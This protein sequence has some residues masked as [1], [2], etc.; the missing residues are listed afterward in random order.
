[1]NRPWVIWTVLGLCALLIVGAMAWST[2]KVLVLE[3]RQTLAESSA[4]LEERIRLSLSRMDIAASGLL[5]LENQRPPHHFKAYFEPEDVFTNKFQVVGKGIVVQPSPLLPELPEFVRL[6]FEVDAATR[7]VNSPQVPTGN[8]R[9]SAEGNGIKT[10]YLDAAFDDLNAL[11]TLLDQPSLSET[12]SQTML[13]EICTAFVSVNDAWGGK[14]TSWNILKSSVVQQKEAWVKEARGDNRA[15]IT[16]GKQYQQEVAIIEKSKRAEVLNDNYERAIPK[17]SQTLR[18]GSPVQI[19]QIAEEVQRQQSSA[20]GPVAQSR[21]VQENAGSSGGYLDNNIVELPMKV[22][23]FQ[24]VWLAKELLIVRQVAIAGKLRYQG[25]WLRAN[26]LSEYLLSAASDLL[27]EAGLE[28]I[29]EISGR[30]LPGTIKVKLDE[31]SNDPLSLVTLPW[32]LRAGEFPVAANVGW[33]ALRISLVVGWVALV[34]ALL[35][36]AVLV[37]GV[38]KLSDR[39]ATFVS[40]VTHELRTPLTT[41][42]LYSDMLVEGMVKDEKKKKEYLTTMRQEAERLNHL[43]ENVLAYSRVERGSARTEHQNV[44]LASL[45]ERM[46]PRL[47]ERVCKD[48]AKLAVESMSDAAQVRVETDLTAVEQIVFNLVDNACKYGLPDEGER[49]IHLR[50]ANGGR[51]ARIEVSDEGGGIAQADEKKLFRPFH[52]SARDAA[53]S[54]PGVGLGLALSRRL[55]RELGGE[56]RID[57]ER[58]RGACFVLELPIAKK[59]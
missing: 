53:H 26:K 37:R 30:L 40:S 54:K 43:V 32:R 18:N 17:Q 4:E 20:Q 19:Q 25:A 27:P 59:R 48:E 12:G 36:S 5:L 3:G 41:F 6:H 23:P 16:R 52:K 24:P 42:H 15:A 33:S 14:G 21:L 1:M 13:D 57:C 55:A 38:M 11:R 56:L 31:L 8:E 50:A 29:L 22:T 9:D 2:N 10:K 39:R 49:I 34:L 7:E 47:M 28:P 51:L 45:L 58:G 46:Q 44:S 35:A